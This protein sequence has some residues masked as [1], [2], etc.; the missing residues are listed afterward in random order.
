ML[1]WGSTQYLIPIFEVAANS[2]PLLHELA[3]S[4]RRAFREGHVYDREGLTLGGGG[5]G[6]YLDGRPERCSH[7]SRIVGAAVGDDDDL[8]LIRLRRGY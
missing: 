1:C 6:Q 5:N 2:V 8:Q 7:P 3:H 4:I